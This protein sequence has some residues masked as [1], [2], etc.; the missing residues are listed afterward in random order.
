MRLL[1]LSLYT[2]FTAYTRKDYRGRIAP[3]DLLLVLQDAVLYL[4]RNADRTM[5]WLL[6]R[7]ASVVYFTHLHFSLLSYLWTVLWLGTRP[8][9]PTEIQCGKYNSSNSPGTP[10]QTKVFTLAPAFVFSRPLHALASE[11]PRPELHDAY[12]GLVLLVTVVASQASSMMA[13][14]GFRWS[15][16]CNLRD[17]EPRQSACFK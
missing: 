10:W 15:G 14:S 12:D 7:P 16:I 8:P 5:I 6:L 1:G 13:F 9:Q 2:A 4:Q 11:K 3:D 17:G